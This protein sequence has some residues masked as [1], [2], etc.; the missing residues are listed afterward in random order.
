MMANDLN[1]VARFDRA[2]PVM[3]MEPIGFERVDHFNMAAQLPVV[4]PRYDRNVATGR[5]ITQQLGG[6]A[7]RGLVVNQ[8]PK[9]DEPLW[10]VFAD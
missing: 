9:N 1:P 4:V 7:P 10:F 8:I 6:F 5:K 3:K 2:M